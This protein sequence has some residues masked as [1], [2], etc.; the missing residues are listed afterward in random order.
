MKTQIWDGYVN[1]S[2]SEV[3]IAERRQLLEKIKKKKPLRGQKQDRE[4]KSEK[5]ERRKEKRTKI[6][7][8]MAGA[9]I[10][11]IDRKTDL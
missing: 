8:Q 2:A 11:S 9:N 6:P 1:D 7:V 3:Q 4:K 10:F 5:V